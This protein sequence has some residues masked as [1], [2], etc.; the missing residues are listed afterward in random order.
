MVLVVMEEA[1]GGGLVV[2][3]LRDLFCVVL[4]LFCVVL[5]NLVIGGW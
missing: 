1:N 2:A 4:L 5:V 3:E